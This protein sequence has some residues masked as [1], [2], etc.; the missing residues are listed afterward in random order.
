M[1]IAHEI[2]LLIRARYPLINIISYE[3]ERLLSTIREVLKDSKNIF[4]WT[5]GDGF[6]VIN[7]RGIYPE[8]GAVDPL[9]ALDRIDK[10]QSEAIFIL[11][12]FH[13]FW[14]D[15]RILVKLRSLCSRLKKKH[16]KYN[17][18]YTCYGYTV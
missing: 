17:S 10:F 2:D 16:K 8:P 14:K 4:S 3:E 15:T 13:L 1:K 7:S 9:V 11:K 12:D 5:L 6:E 18:Y